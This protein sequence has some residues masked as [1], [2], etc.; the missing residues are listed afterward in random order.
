MSAGEKEWEELKNIQ[1]IE[2][3]WKKNHKNIENKANLREKQRQTLFQLY[4]A[5]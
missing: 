1:N 4:A 3:K 5:H 2:Q